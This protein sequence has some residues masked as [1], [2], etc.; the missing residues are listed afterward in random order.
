MHVEILHH[1][2]AGKASI[3]LDGDLL[4]DQELH[5]DNQRHLIFHVVEMNQVANFEFAAGKHKV[6]VLVVAPES[7]YDQSQTITADFKPGPAHTLAINC[8]KRK[9]QVSLR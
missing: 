5:G 9:M 1:F 3:W 7:A 8:D 4:F 6:Q 2:S